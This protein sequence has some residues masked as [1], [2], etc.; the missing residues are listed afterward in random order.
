[1]RNGLWRSW[2]PEGYH[3]NKAAEPEWRI[4]YMIHWRSW[5]RFEIRLPKLIMGRQDR[6]TI[7]FCAG[8]MQAIAEVQ[9]VAS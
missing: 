2:N 6:H 4:W 9:A 8:I 3:W 7:V 1:M 5:D